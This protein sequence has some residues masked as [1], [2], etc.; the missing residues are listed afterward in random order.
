MSKAEQ[1]KKYNDKEMTNEPSGTL[2]GSTYENYR[3]TFINNGWDLDNSFADENIMRRLFLMSQ[4]SLAPTSVKEKFNSL[5]GTR[6]YNIHERN[7]ALRDLGSFLQK[8]FPKNSKNEFKNM[9]DDLRYY[10]DTA[11]SRTKD[12]EEAQNRTQ[13]HVANVLDVIEHVQNVSNLAF[14]RFNSAPYKGQPDLDFK[15]ISLK[16]NNIN[17]IIH[18]FNAQFGP[19]MDSQNAIGGEKNIFQFVN[20]HFKVMKPGAKNAVGLEDRIKDAYAAAKKNDKT[21]KP[22]KGN[23]QKYLDAFAAAYI[24]HNMRDSQTDIFFEP[25]ANVGKRIYDRKDPVAQY[26]NL[27]KKKNIAIGDV[28]P[29][30]LE[31]NTSKLSNQGRARLERTDL[32]AYERYS[33]VFES[34]RP[35]QVDSK[36]TISKLTQ[37]KAIDKMIANGWTMDARLSNVVSS[38]FDA[39]DSE[40]KNAPTLEN[41]IKKLTT[42]KVINKENALTTKVETLSEI[43]KMLDVHRID[44]SIKALS[45]VIERTLSTDRSRVAEKKLDDLR[46]KEKTITVRRV[47]P[48]ANMGYNDLNMHYGNTLWYT[49]IA[50]APNGDNFLRKIY[51]LSEHEG[52][53]PILNDGMYNLISSGNEKGNAGVYETFV[54]MEADISRYLSENS[55]KSIGENNYKNIKSLQDHLQ[56]MIDYFS[57]D[58]RNEMQEAHNK[59]WNSFKTNW[60]Q[61]RRKE[62]PLRANGVLSANIGEPNAADL[63]EQQLNAEREQVREVNAEREP[64][65]E[66]KNEEKQ[67]EEVK[68]EEVKEEKQPEEAPKEEIKVEAAPQEEN[69][70]P[71]QKQSEQ[72]EPEVTD[73]DFEKALAEVDV[74]KLADEFNNDVNEV[75]NGAALPNEKEVYDKVESD[76]IWEIGEMAKADVE[77]YP[78]MDDLIAEEERKNQ[79]EIDR[80]LEDIRPKA[81]DYPDYETVFI[82]TNYDQIVMDTL[83]NDE[84][85][86][87]REDNVKVGGMSIDEARQN[88]QNSGWITD[89]PQVENFLRLFYDTYSYVDDKTKKILDS[90][91][92]VVAKTP[93][94]N[95]LV[96]DAL[97]A[98]VAGT[99]S[100]IEGNKYIDTFKHYINGTRDLI[101]GNVEEIQHQINLEK[102][103][104]VAKAKAEREAE[105][106]QLAGEE[107]ELA[108]FLKDDATLAKEKANREQT[109][110]KLRDLLYRFS[111]NGQ[112]EEEIDLPTEEEIEEYKAR[113]NFENSIP[114]VNYP[115]FSENNN[116]AHQA[117]MDEVKG[118]YRDVY[119]KNWK[120]KYDE[121]VKEQ[122]AAKK[123]AEEEKA[124]K[125]AEEKRLAEEKAKKEA[126]E[127]RIAEEKAKKEA[128]EKRLADEKARKERLEKQR[129][130]NEER[131]RKEAEEKARKAAEAKKAHDDWVA[132]QERKKVEEENRKKQEDMQDVS[133]QNSKKMVQLRGFEFENE[134]PEDPEAAKQLKKGSIKFVNDY[135]HYRFAKA[136][137]L[138][139]LESF[140]KT[141]R[142]VKKQGDLP[143]GGENT[144]TKPYRDMASALGTCIKNLKGKGVHPN[145]I[146][147]SLRD[148]GKACD[149]YYDKRKPTFG[150]KE[151]DAAIRLDF[152]KNGKDRALEMAEIFGNYRREFT[153]NRDVKYV[154]K[155][156]KNA[157]MFSPNVVVKHDF[158]GASEFMISEKCKALQESYEFSKRERTNDAFEQSKKYNAQNALAVEQVKLRRELEKVT[159]KTIGVDYKTENSVVTNI[160][161]LN[162]NGKKLTPAQCAKNYI[163]ENCAHMLMDPKAT[164][165]MLKKSHE[166]LEPKKLEADIKALANNPVFKAYAEKDG[167]VSYDDWH[168]AS[169]NAARLMEESKRKLVMKGLGSN[170]YRVM[171][172]VI[173]KQH[174]YSAEDVDK[175]YDKLGE[176][177]FAQICSENETLV[178][179]LLMAPS[180]KRGFLAQTID[181]LKKNEKC[182]EMECLHEVEFKE[183]EMAEDIKNRLE[184]SVRNNELKNY[185]IKTISKGA[186]LGMEKGAEKGKSKTTG[187]KSKS[188]DPKKKDMSK[189]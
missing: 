90:Q 43:K 35:V 136:E 105:A 92:N 60:E 182:Q 100:G 130:E 107:K 87:V 162:E 37:K 17:E 47:R 187:S 18:Q 118:H 63:R 34:N 46:N 26:L 95:D 186:N 68:Q 160:L 29:A 80:Q 99:L 120:I 51:R 72:N 85:I 143:L 32:D 155:P 181:A 127:K 67:V 62:N 76:P 13:R 40:K 126:E 21:F 176:I 41:A 157:K 133:L 2:D 149:D 73:E 183:D 24:M 3:N 144:G 131:L 117:V 119:D 140:E 153:N 168:Y 151:G 11:V 74:Q 19:L 42:T 58:A 166:G 45:D 52:M 104:E 38:I 39:Y 77:S 179:G 61:N 185:V 78:T 152:A 138:K 135:D 123:K 175:M 145:D 171:D 115:E 111:H 165:E 101:R 64:E 48:L 91:I 49:N 177:V 122:E 28:P 7:E 14:P 23:E 81:E 150:K 158:S 172:G 159:G 15:S 189:K 84:I 169:T 106:A 109:Q 103:E 154:E 33:D 82:D 12:K 20:K 180:S 141:L 178:Q 1:V 9:A 30:I 97:F 164:P 86:K 94:E 54:D 129:K 108:D 124:R 71:E 75:I 112:P 53:R 27:N 116:E 70:A 137:L 128:E 147:K 55:K 134:I 139:E 89:V 4:S 170:A 148:F 142:S 173:P 102:T 16:D 50:T 6:I 69:K 31:H 161:K 121:F 56:L 114:K 57:R 83:H 98:N 8:E 93:V 132:E 156:F 66:V 44:K 79:E 167:N 110:A 59:E 188:T 22:E 25:Y 146:E 163:L 113:R 125:E 5:M 10:M 96:A 65:S 36:K 184:R 88:M 174:K